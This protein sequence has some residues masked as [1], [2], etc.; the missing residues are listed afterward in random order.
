M[1]VLRL[2]S[3]Y[4]TEACEWQAATEGWMQLAS[5][6]TNCGNR[7]QFEEACNLCGWVRHCYM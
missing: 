1:G 7:R 3:L 5:M 2:T 6:A 4:Y